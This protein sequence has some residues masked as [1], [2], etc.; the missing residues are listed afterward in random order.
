MKLLVHGMQSS[1]ASSF[2]MFLAQRPE[3][4]ALVDTLNNFAAPRV[5]TSLDFV[6]KVVIT[7]AYPLAV[8]VDRFRPDRTILF[9]RDPRDNYVSLRSKNYRNYSGLMREKFR[10]L[11]EIFAARS[12]YDAVIHYEDF[13][14]R[15]PDVIAA[16]R[17]LGWPVE[18]AH[19][20]FS[21]RHEHILQALWQHVPELMEDFEIGFGNLQGF[22]VSERFRDKPADPEV[23]A[24]LE[25]LCPRLLAYYRDRSMTHYPC[26]DRV[27]AVQ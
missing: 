22:E 7:T 8:H 18:E 21:R 19:Y 14:A 13:V 16:I 12:R 15:D 17:R 9:L 25:A 26:G 11:E 20:A 23:D 24:R 6:V 10:L 1:G 3:A 4:L 2:T 27:A 5:S